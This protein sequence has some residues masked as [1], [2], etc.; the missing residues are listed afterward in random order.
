MRFCRFLPVFDGRR[1]SRGGRGSGNRPG[2]SRLQNFLDENDQDC[3]FCEDLALP[4]L[5]ACLPCAF[6]GV[7]PVLG[8]DHPLRSSRRGGPYGA[9]LGPPSC[10]WGPAWGPWGPTLCCGFALLATC[11]GLLALAEYVQQESATRIAISFTMVAHTTATR[12][13]C[14]SRKSRSAAGAHGGPMGAP[15]GP[16]AQNHDFYLFFWSKRAG[17]HP[18]GTGGAGGEDPAEYRGDS[19]Y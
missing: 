7:P 10:P 18:T 15:M 17:R 3:V 12:V 13:Q 5:F 8:C 6:W 4:G 14:A 2:I 19:L 1:S 16:R 11:R 9:L